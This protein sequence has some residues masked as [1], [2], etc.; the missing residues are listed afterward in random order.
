MIALLVLAVLQHGGKPK[1]ADAQ[2]LE[3]VQLIAQAIERAALE[4]IVGAIPRVLRRRSRVIEAVDQRK[5]DPLIAPVS[6]GWKR[7]GPAPK[8]LVPP[9]ARRRASS[10]AF[11]ISRSQIDNG[12][13]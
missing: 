13:S 5:I 9:C 2:L 12:I 7:R 3:I 1:R 10:K 11:C 4:G 6:R 8:L